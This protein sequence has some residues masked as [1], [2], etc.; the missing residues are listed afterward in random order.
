[1]SLKREKVTNALKFL[2]IIILPYLLITIFGFL[3]PERFSNIYLNQVIEILVFFVIPFL[4]IKYFYKGEIFFFKKINFKILILSVLFLN[5]ATGF[6]MN[7]QQ[8]ISSVFLN[9]KIISETYIDAISGLFEKDKIFALFAIVFAAPI[10]E[11]FFYRGV[12]SFSRDF[13]NR[14]LFLIFYPLISSLVFAFSH[15]DFY[16]LPYLIL[17]GIGFAI[18]F[19]LTEN[20]LYSI[21]YHFLTNLLAF[22]AL[23]FSFRSDID[24]KSVTKLSE[25][26]E[27]TIFFII[28]MIIDLFILNV[29]FRAIVFESNVEKIYKRLLQEGKMVSKKRIR[30]N[31][32]FEKYYKS[33]SEYHNIKEKSVDEFLKKYY[34]HFQ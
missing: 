8:F 3:V 4:M 33:Y 10:I 24:L 34:R 13:L 26:S 18:I 5:F 28:W 25:G 9:S 30:E 11:E 14:K 29:L 19:M 6:A 7:V 2:L 32:R 17:I 31:L 23:L 27:S 21:I 15:F 1:M 12:F 22:S 16:R 20:L